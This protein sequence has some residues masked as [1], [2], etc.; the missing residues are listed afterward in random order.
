[1]GGIEAFLNFTTRMGVCAGK[2]PCAMGRGKTRMGM[3]TLCVVVTNL[4]AEAKR[5]D[6]IVLG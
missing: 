4:F 6:G 1:M 5:R 3:E 2:M